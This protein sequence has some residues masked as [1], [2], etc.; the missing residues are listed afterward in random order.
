ML[1]FTVFGTGLLALIHASVTRVES[2]KANQLLRAGYTYVDVRTP[3]EHSISHIPGSIN[4]PYSFMSSTGMM[5]S[6]PAFVQQVQARFPSSKQLLL[7]GCRTG[8]R[9]AKAVALLQQHY[10]N[11]LEHKDGFVGWTAARLPL[12]KGPAVADSAAR[13]G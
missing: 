5:T 8:S 10:P 3:E 1:G 6:N 12:Q 11:L 13:S 7:V 9:S 4:I 2:H